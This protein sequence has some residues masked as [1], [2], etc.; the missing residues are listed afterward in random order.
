MRFIVCD[1]VVEPAIADAIEQDMS[2]PRFPWFFYANVNFGS[3]PPADRPGAFQ[4]DARF[5]A[6][7]GFSSLLFPGNEP[8]S[9]W[10]EYPKRVFE[11]FAKRHGLKPTQ[12]LRIKANL[13]VRSAAPG[14]PRPFTPH[15]DIP[16]P[17]LVLIYYVNDSDGDTVILDKTYPDWAD[18]GVL[19]SISPKKGRA[20]LFDGRHY[21]CGTC[22]SGHDSRIVLNYD[23]V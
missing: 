5:E 21:H 14:G 2:S 22:P 19:H 3:R 10:L 20:I 4:T 23:F 15:V 6:S 18:A 1:D 11:G 7:F 9:P 12:M 16:K 8:I 17:H 13:L